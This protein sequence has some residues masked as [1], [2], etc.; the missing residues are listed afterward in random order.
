MK[1][2]PL[3]IA[4]RGQKKKL[5]EIYFEFTSLKA[6]E[7]FLRDSEF[8]IL[9]DIPLDFWVDG[10]KIEQDDYLPD[11]LKKGEILYCY[12]KKFYNKE[13]FGDYDTYK[14][15]NI[16]FRD[17]FKECHFQRLLVSLSK[18]KTHQKDMIGIEYLKKLRLSDYEHI[19][20][21]FLSVI[22][23]PYPDW[24][25]R[26]DTSQIYFLSNSKRHIFM[27]L[28]DQAVGKNVANIVFDFFRETSVAGDEKYY[29]G[30]GTNLQEWYVCCYISGILPKLTAKNFLVSEKFDLNESMHKNP[31]NYEDLIGP[32]RSL[33]NSDTNEKIIEVSLLFFSVLFILK[34]LEEHGSL[35]A[36]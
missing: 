31:R 23:T 17:I 9:P 20:S 15:L 32:I 27:V 14:C 3:Q 2:N 4:F 13:Y 26:Q 11:V 34:F 16:D 5:P 22:I 28:N 21:S 7:K 35:E 30:I 19:L 33:L 10:L 12:P 36:V 18:P 24:Y 8:D 6:L 25:W 29:L 1:K